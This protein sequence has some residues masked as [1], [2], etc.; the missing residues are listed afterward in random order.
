MADT[1]MLKTFYENMKKFRE[2]LNEKIANA[3]PEEETAT[4]TSSTQHEKND[5]QQE[6]T[7]NRT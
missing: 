3:P 5:T 6:T 4:P 2:Q 1:N 7:S